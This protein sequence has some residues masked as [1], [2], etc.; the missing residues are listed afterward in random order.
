MSKFQRRSPAHI[1]KSLDPL[2]IEIEPGFRVR[3]LCTPAECATAIL[4]IEN[5]MSLIAGQIARAEANPEMVSP[6]WRTKAQN[7]QRWK[8]RTI[9]AIR[10]HGISLAKTTIGEKERRRQY[11][12]KVIEDEV[13]T[14]AM[15]RYV[16]LTRQRYPSAFGTVDNGEN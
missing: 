4:K 6:G 12:L 11:I 5:D 14:E 9:K 8:K 10:E 3:Q 7:A 16:A 1:E 2:D 13:G 15:D